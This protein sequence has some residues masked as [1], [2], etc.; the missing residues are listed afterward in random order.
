MGQG[1]VGKTAMVVR[2]QHNEFIEGYMPTIGDMYTTDVESPMGPRHCEIDDTAGQVRSVLNGGCA[3]CRRP[4][5]PCACCRTLCPPPAPTPLTQSPTLPTSL[6]HRRNPASLP[7][8]LR[9]L[10]RRRPTRT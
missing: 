5:F 3:W 2:Y 10:L 8:P 1:G 4:F 9:L 6:P 7:A